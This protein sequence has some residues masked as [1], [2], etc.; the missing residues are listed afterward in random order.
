[1]I[2]PSNW[3][4]PRAWAMPV[5]LGALAGCV[6]HTST[7]R[8]SDESRTAPDDSDVRKR[9]RARLELASSYYENGQ[10]AIALD[11]AQKVMQVDP[12]FSEGYNLSGLIYLAMNEQN[13]AQNHFERAISLAPNNADALHNLGWLQCQMGRY[14]VAEQSFQRAMAVPLYPSR[15]KTLMAQGVCQARGGDKAKAEATLRRSYELDPGNPVTGYS[16]AQ[17]LYQR[18]NYTWAKFY[19]RRINNSEQANAQSL[20]LGINIERRLKN[21]VAMQQL[22]GQLGRRFAQSREFQNYQKGAFDE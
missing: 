4:P 13:L 20:W 7:S 8:I 9:A 10:H 18:R 1:M 22:A 19:I 15:A 21:S 5:L 6:S 2:A 16:L 11:E 3:M 12:S 17:L 14:A